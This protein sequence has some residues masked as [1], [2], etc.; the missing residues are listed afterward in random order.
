MVEGEASPLPPG[1]VSHSGAKLLMSS[2]NPQFV[3]S[4]TSRGTL[5][6]LDPMEVLQGM[7][8]GGRDRPTGEHGEVYGEQL[9]HFG[10][11]EELA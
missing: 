8:S 11:L 7:G 5:L 2:F 6:A 1:V 3:S 4:L 9:F 10:F